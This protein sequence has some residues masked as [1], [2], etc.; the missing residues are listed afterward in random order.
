MYKVISNFRDLKDRQ[1][2]YRV[3]DE[4]PRPGRS[5]SEDRLKALITGNNK[6]KKPLIE[7]IVEKKPVEKKPAKKT[8]TKKTAT[9]KAAKE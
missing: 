7:E 2:L 1:Y 6:A 4:Y 5:V 8:T 9:K 3:G